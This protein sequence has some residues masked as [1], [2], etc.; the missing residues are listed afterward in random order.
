MRKKTHNNTGYSWLFSPRI[1]ELVTSSKSMSRSPATRFGLAKLGAFASWASLG[2]VLHVRPVLYI[3][4]LPIVF[5]G[6]TGCNDFGL[7]KGPPA[8]IDA[9]AVQAAASNQELII[10]ALAQDAGSSDYYRIAEAGFNYVDDQCQLYFDQIFFLDRERS[11]IKSGLAA[12][13]ATSAA[14][15]GVAKASTLSLSV[16]ASAFGFASAA[17]DIVAGTY[18]YS[19]PPSTTQGLVNKLQIAYRAQALKSRADINS[20]TAAY[21]QVQGYLALCLPPRIEAE[22]IRSV[23]ASSTQLTPGSSGASFS[24][25]SAGPSPPATIVKVLAT[26]PVPTPTPP[27]PVDGALNPVEAKL[28]LRFLTRVQNALCVPAS[29]VWDG[30]TRDAIR[31]FFAGVDGAAFANGQIV[32]NSADVHSYLPTKGITVADAGVLTHSFSVAA[33]KSSCKDLKGTE[34]DDWRHKLGNGM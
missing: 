26:N 30:P 23:N 4:L 28:G 17:T 12:A 24:V 32:P 6:L 8:V 29:G 11:Q 9:T 16:V 31:A 22:V 13:S 19:L 20:Q 7:R 18:L 14:I 3:L 25:Q 34:L 15:L 33:S 27:A 2:T 10:N 21:H 5:F 1:L